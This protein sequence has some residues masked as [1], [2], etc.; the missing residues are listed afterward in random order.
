MS[1]QNGS[2]IALR[3]QMLRVLESLLQQSK[4]LRHGEHAEPSPTHA[5]YVGR[6]TATDDDSSQVEAP[7]QGQ[8]P[9]FGLHAGAQMPCAL[10]SVL[11][12]TRS[13]LR[14]QSKSESQTEQYRRFT[15]ALRSSVMG[16][17]R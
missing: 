10:E 4:S 1:M 12:H 13:G 14:E 9:T 16:P 5:P 6:H 2:P 7:I 17:S 15:H 11:E 3:Q 8:P